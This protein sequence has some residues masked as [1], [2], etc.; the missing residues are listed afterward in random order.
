[1]T[2]SKQLNGL[3]IGLL[4]GSSMFAQSTARV[5]RSPS[6][7]IVMRGSRPAPP[8]EA[9]AETAE[10]AQAPA[11]N[12]ETPA[13]VAVRMLRNSGDVAYLSAGGSK[14]VQL[15][16]TESTYH[17]YGSSGEVVPA[18]TTRT[19]IRRLSD[20]TIE[21]VAAV[22]ATNVNGR[23]VLVRK[24]TTRERTVGGKTTSVKTTERPSI[25]GGFR[26]AERLESV[27]TDNGNAGTTVDTVRFIHTGVS[28]AL[29]E[30]GRESSVMRQTDRGA[31]TETT[32]YERSTVNGKTVLAGRT[33]GR[34]TQEEDGSVRET[35]EVYGRYAGTQEQNPLQLER[36]VKRSVT[37]ARNG[38]V[39]ES[40]SSVGQ[41]AMAGTD[42]R[43]QRVARLTDDG[44]V[45]VTTFEQNANGQ[46][47]AKGVSVEPLDQAP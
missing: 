13:Q 32:I 47:Y 21:T 43:T 12:S 31:T 46:M 15:G 9:A 10:A 28:A 17:E 26:A 14:Q 38:D 40:L 1:M 4:I 35:I 20:G 29:V 22:F 45:E 19:T 25:N 3:W 2:P 23:E 30:V 11:E 42:F 41:G 33:V 44:I 7:V 6:G 27:T 34:L 16:S 24:E 37:V 5:E 8:P 39:N 36:V 18:D